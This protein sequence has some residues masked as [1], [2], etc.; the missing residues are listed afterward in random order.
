[1]NGLAAASPVCVRDE[2][3]RGVRVTEQIHQQIHPFPVGAAALQI[4]H[5]SSFHL[6]TSLL[7]MQRGSDNQIL[8]AQADI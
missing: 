4:W 7:N 8:C 6:P 3:G 2:L 5:D 1:M